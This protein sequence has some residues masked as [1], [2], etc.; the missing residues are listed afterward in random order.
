MASPLK[1]FT[2]VILQSLSS[3]WVGYLQRV[4][5][6]TL[7]CD[8]V[9]S[10][11]VGWYQ[12]ALMGVSGPAETVVTKRFI[13]SPLSVFHPSFW[14]PGSWGLWRGHVTAAV[15]LFPRKNIIDQA[16]IC[17]VLSFKLKYNYIILRATTISNSPNFRHPFCNFSSFI[18]TYFF[19]SIELF[20]AECL[21]AFVP[22][23][24]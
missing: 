15:T 6:A 1:N 22:C 11:A 23:F 12:T 24:C 5:L 4:W 8:K 14:E 21:A 3:E 10:V 17:N 18:N 20:D 16:L 7:S 2:P 19:F 13:I 9:L